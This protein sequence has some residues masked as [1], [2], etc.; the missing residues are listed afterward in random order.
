MNPI[1]PDDEQQAMLTMLRLIHEGA[2]VRAEKVRRI[3]ELLVAGMYEN[4]MKIQIAGE[5]AIA[6][7]EESSLLFPPPAGEG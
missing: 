5:R 3:R 2:D 6:D 1:R 4:A 7:M